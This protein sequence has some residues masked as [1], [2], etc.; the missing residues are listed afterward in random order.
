MDRPRPALREDEHDRFPPPGKLLNQ[1]QLGILQR[2]I[3]DVA[4]EFTVS[5][6]SETRNHNVGRIRSPG[7]RGDIQR[8]LK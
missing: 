6:F 3:V 5:L 2:E 4:D 1:P 8:L 7:G